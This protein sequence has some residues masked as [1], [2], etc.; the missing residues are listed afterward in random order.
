MNP[1]F[2]PILDTNV[3]TLCQVPTQPPARHAQV[4]CKRADAKTLQ[5]ELTLY[6]ISELIDGQ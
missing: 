6:L 1:I 2:R 4:N 5:Q 3:E